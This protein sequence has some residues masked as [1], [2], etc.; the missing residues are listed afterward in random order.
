MVSQLRTRRQDV[1]CQRGRTSLLWWAE[2]DTY[3]ADSEG[4]VVVYEVTDPTTLVAPVADAKT[5]GVDRAI[6]ATD[7]SPLTVTGTGA[8]T[9]QGP[10]LMTVDGPGGHER[11]GAW[12]VFNLTPAG[13][14][15]VALNAIDTRI[16]NLSRQ[17]YDR[18]SGVDDPF[19]PPSGFT[20]LSQLRVVKGT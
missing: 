19:L 7:D 16:V 1:T 10:F 2:G 17:A 15:A 11:Y 3:H 6:A 9:Y 18:V 4:G 20:D 8:G 5:A 12:R 14:G 13:G